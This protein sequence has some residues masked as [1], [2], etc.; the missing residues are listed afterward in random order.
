MGKQDRWS[1]VVL[2][3]LGTAIC[4]G[5]LK[6][7][8]GTMAAPGPGLLPFL[9]GVALC[10][11]SVGI[12]LIAGGKKRSIPAAS[13]NFFPYADSKRIVVLVLLSL[14]GYNLLWGILGFSLTTFIFLTFLFWFVGNRNWRIALMSSATISFLAYA[15]FEFFLEAQLPTGYVGF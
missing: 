2:F 15:L 7:G 14:F 8:L 3:L 1:S 4:F 12:F 5:S 10:L 9:A 6:L 13:V 11:F